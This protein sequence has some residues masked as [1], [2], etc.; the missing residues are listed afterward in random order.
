[1]NVCVCVCVCVCVYV[2]MTE[3]TVLSGAG[4]E[5]AICNKH[6]HVTRSYQSSA[7]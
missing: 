4:H 2:G 6:T 1:M 7:Q 5:Q 3:N